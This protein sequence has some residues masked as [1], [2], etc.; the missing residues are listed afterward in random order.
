[1][2]PVVANV[3]SSHD[4]DFDGGEDFSAQLEAF[5]REQAAEA[6]AVEAYGDS[7][8]MGTILKYTDKHAI[9]DVGLKSEGT[10][11]H[12]AGC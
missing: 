11:P 10:A 3:A 5:E 9:I 4:H 8:V 12:R 7:V 1:M 6:A 2:I